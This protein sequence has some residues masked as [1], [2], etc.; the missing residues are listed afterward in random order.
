MPF[1]FLLTHRSAMVQDGAEP[2]HHTS[3]YASFFAGCEDVPFPFVLT[4]SL[5]TLDHSS[6]GA[7][8]G[9]NR[10]GF[11]TLPGSSPPLIAAMAITPTGE[12]SAVSQG[13][14]SVPTAWWCDR[15][16]P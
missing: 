14:C 13:R 3:L 15:V 11:M 5:A 10:P 2:R 6:K 16:A 12:M 9:R 1:P 8:D 7:V 4:A